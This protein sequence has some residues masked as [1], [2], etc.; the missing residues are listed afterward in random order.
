MSGVAIFNM[1]LTIMN[2]DEQTKKISQVLAKCWSDESFKQKLMADPVGTLKAEGATMPDGLSVKVV[3]NT[4]EV[5]NLVIPAKATD[6]TD[7][8][9]DK[10]AGGQGNFQRDCDF[11]EALGESL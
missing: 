2:Q 11:V 6:L 7:A 5:F 4:D 1:E 8:D 10:V 3:E 9:L